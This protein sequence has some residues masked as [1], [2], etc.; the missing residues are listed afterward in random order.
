MAVTATVIVLVLTQYAVHWVRRRCVGHTADE[1]PRY[2][3]FHAMF[4][5]TACFC[6]QGK[7]L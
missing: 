7:N 1:I 2:G 3:I 4:N 5:I 6:Y